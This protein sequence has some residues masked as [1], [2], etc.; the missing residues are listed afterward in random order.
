MREGHRCHI[1]AFAVVAA[2]DDAAVVLFRPRPGVTLKITF[3]SESDQM[4][5]NPMSAPYA[6]LRLQIPL[7]VRAFTQ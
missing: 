5:Q 3:S 1:A 7:P 2:P 6:E 4:R